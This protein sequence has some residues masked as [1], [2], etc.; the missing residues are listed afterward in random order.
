VTSE[1]RWAISSA[2]SWMRERRL[3]V[4]D[5]MRDRTDALSRRWEARRERSG[6]WHDRVQDWRDHVQDWRDRVQDWRDGASGSGSRARIGGRRDLREHWTR[7]PFGRPEMI[8]L[9][10][11]TTVAALLRFWDLGRTGFR[12]DEAVYAGQAAV[13]AG[14]Q[15]MDRHFILASRG[16][17]NFLLFQEVLSLVYRVVGV[18]DVTARVVSATMSVAT[19]VVVYFIGRLLRGPRVAACAAVVLALSGYAVGLGRLALLDS[20]AALMVAV[21]LL[22]AVLWQRTPRALWLC[23]LFASVALAVQAKVTTGLLAVAFAIALLLLQWWRE[24]DRRSLGLAVLAGL[25]ALVPAFVQVSANANIMWDFLKTSLHRASPVPWYYYLSTLV[26]YDGLVFVVILLAA[27]VA[28]AIRSTRRDVVIWAWVGVFTVFLIAYPLKAFNY[29]LPLL[30]ALA[31][32]AGIGLASI[33]VPRVRPAYLAAAATVVGLGVSAP[34]LAA[35]VE[36]DSSAGMREAA[37]WI[38]DNTAP[39]DGVMTLSHGSAQYV[40]PFYSGHDG[41]PYGRFRLDTVLPGGSVV[42]APVTSRGQLPI[43]WVSG[44]PQKLIGDGRVNYL[45]YVTN[46]L[47]DP[48]EQDQFVGTMTQRDFRGLIEGY[49]GQLVHTVYYHHEGRAFIYRVTKRAP[50]PTV[51]FA[52]ASIDHLRVTGRGFAPLAAVS[53]TYHGSPV[54]TTKTD[55]NGLVDLTLAMPDRAQLAYHLVLTDAQGN[56]A[57]TTGLPA[58]SVSYVS[59]D[60]KLTV[61]GRSY[62]PG[63]AVTVYYHEK[64]IAR[65]RAGKDGTVVIRV[66]LPASSQSRYRLRLTDD[67]G[68]TAWATGLAAPVMKASLEGTTVKVSGDNF[69]PDS[70]VAV[71]YHGVSLGRASTDSAGTFTATMRLTVPLRAGYRLVVT[72]PAGRR[73]SVVGLSNEHEVSSASNGST[74]GGP[75]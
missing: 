63:S 22:F 9:A 26:S 56:A 70:S 47:D 64:A 19:V 21:S 3:D 25:V 27:V 4:T 50:R 7:I 2:S 75:R 29:V 53:V 68:R 13:L 59:E 6:G 35:A 66:P 15:G 36:D 72:D 31:V 62:T 18:G 17:S 54:A 38:K 16:N 5:S 20:T 30:P 43:E 12:G 69:L 61:T 46:P 34:N 23:A 48:P 44:W 14:D 28:G 52:P 24:L 37:L 49:G 42:S 51:D 8:V 1:R 39:G 58:S 10:V 73:A 65:A 57:S 67:E 55:G 40:I 71:G 45:I 11:I 41:Y 32:L 33:T 74:T 60:G